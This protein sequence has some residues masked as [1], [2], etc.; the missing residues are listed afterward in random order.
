MATGH[1]SVFVHQLS[2]ADTWAVGDVVIKRERQ[3]RRRITFDKDWDPAACYFEVFVAKHH[4]D[5]Q[6]QY[7]MT[8]VLGF[9][10]L[11]WNPNWKCTLTTKIK[12]LWYRRRQTTSGKVFKSTHFHPGSSDSLAEMESIASH[13]EGGGRAGVF[14]SHLL[15]GVAKIQAWRPTSPPS[16]PPETQIRPLATSSRAPPVLYVRIYGPVDW[17]HRGDSSNHPM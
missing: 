16:R 13:Q 17:A 10:R 9:R 5:R 7:T 4:F 2:I 8:G 15:R 11:R 1:F 6:M 14:L 12:T 3:R